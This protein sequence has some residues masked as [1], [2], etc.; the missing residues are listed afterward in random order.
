MFGADQANNFNMQNSGTLSETIRLPDD[1]VGLIIGRGGENI[2]K[3]Q[4][5]TGCRIQITQSIPGTKER[6][7]TLSGTQEQIEVCKNMLDEIV[8]RSKANGMT[9]GSIQPGFGNMGGMGDGQQQGLGEETVE[10]QIPPERCGLVIGKGGETIKMLQTSLQVKMLLIQDSVECHGISKPLRIS[11]EKQKVQN[12]VNAI[13]QMLQQREAQ[14]QGQAMGRSNNGMN[15]GGFGGDNVMKIQVPKNAVGVVIGKGGEMINQIQGQTGTRV[16][17]KP[18]DQHA[19]E[20]ECTISGMK[21][22]VDQAVR[23]IQDL[24]NQV[25]ERDGNSGGNYGGNFGHWEAPNM[26]GNMGNQTTEEHLVPANRTGLVIGKGGET[27]KQINAQ[28]GARA[29]IV[30]DPPANSDPN[31]KIFNIKGTPEQIKMCRQLIQEKVDGNMG[32]SS[33]SNSGSNNFTTQ[34]FG[35]Q[36]QQPAAAMSNQFGGQ[37]N[38][39]FQQQ[40]QQQT[41]QWAPTPQPNPAAANSGALGGGPLVVDYSKQWAEYF[42]NTGQ[43]QEAARMMAGA[44]GDNRTQQAAAA[45]AAAAQAAAAP[46]AAAAG[47]T[48]YT[49]QWAEYYRQLALQQQ[50]FGVQQQPPQ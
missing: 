14:V 32:S 29:Q 1:M 48:D 41:P 35:G 18:E 17:F 7:C 30:K 33:H 50:Q 44:G 13:N 9:S 11:G 26:Q 39:G 23:R 34:Q 21:E 12:A 46:Q 28:S 4:R 6:P 3:M 47:Q 22:G 19:P 42:K 45:Q 38:G 25:Q 15:G 40:Q 31:Y 2:M 20:R 16:Q 43:V 37:F 8:A 49:A 5:E 27:I 10:L 36:F 24:I